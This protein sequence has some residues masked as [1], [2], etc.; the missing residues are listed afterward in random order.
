[1]GHTSLHAM[2]LVFILNGTGNMYIFP[3]N[4]VKNIGKKIVLVLLAYLAVVMMILFAYKWSS[5]I[6]QE[7][8]KKQSDVTCPFHNPDSHSYR[9]LDV[10]N[11]ERIP[12]IT[13]MEILKE[14]EDMGYDIY[15]EMENWTFTPEFVGQTYKENQGHIHVYLDGKKAGRMYGNYYYLG[16]LSKGKHKIAITINGDDHTAF[17]V[18]NKHGKDIMIGRTETIIVD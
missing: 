15:V 6:Q 18:K 11:A 9:M 17:T 2:L 5:E 13:K 4:R 8:V 16:K 12:A 1:M 14:P 7:R 3:L 10:T